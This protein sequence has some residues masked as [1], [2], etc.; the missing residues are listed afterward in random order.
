M[1][2]LAVGEV[3]GKKT[4]LGIIPTFEEI[5]AGFDEFIPNKGYTKE[6]YDKQFSLYVDNLIARIDLQ[7]EAYKKE[8]NVPEIYFETQA[9]KK[10][11]LEALKAEKGA[12]VKPEDL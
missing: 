7:V 11:R 6:F 2:K 1:A 8:V 12:I 9:A 4:A 10:A 5:S 3:T